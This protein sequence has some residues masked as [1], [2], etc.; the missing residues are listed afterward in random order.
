MFLISSREVSLLA[1]KEWLPAR[2]GQV[3][4]LS[5]FWGVF[6]VF[7]VFRCTFWWKTESQTV[8]RFVPHGARTMYQAFVELEGGAGKLLC[9]M[10]KLSESMSRVPKV[11][12]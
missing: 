1:G 12:P 4:E 8:L 2:F 10:Q 6:V 9:D 5:T 3:T 11:H 7:S